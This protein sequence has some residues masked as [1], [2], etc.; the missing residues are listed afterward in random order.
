ML[1]FPQELEEIYRQ[2]ET[3]TRNVYCLAFAPETFKISAFTSKE[4]IFHS[5]N[6]L[7]RETENGSI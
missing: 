6:L 7:I 3:L 5:I 4:E 2:S 1:D